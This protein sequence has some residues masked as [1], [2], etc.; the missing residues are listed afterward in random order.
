MIDDLVARFSCHARTTLKRVRAQSTASSSIGHVAG[1]QPLTPQIQSLRNIEYKTGE[2]VYGASESRVDVTEHDKK[3]DERG[4]EL[5]GGT[6]VIS[7]T[8][9]PKRARG[10][11]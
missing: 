9:A 2:K 4:Q 1:H 10:K 6:F 8:V 7:S 11:G 5:D 3:K